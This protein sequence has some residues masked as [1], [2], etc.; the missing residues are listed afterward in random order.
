MKL[1]FEDILIDLIKREGGFVDD[2]DDRGGATNLGITIGTLRRHNLDLDGDGDVDAEDVKLVDFGVAKKLYKEHYWTPS[3]AAE[4]SPEISPLYFDM[5][6]NHGQRHA[7]RILQ[8]AANDC[9][10]SLK[11]DGVIGPNTIKASFHVDVNRVVSY[12]ILFYSAI[13]HS[14]SSQQ[15]FWFGWLKRALE[16][17]E[18]Q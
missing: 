17:W 11:V 3:K 7:A 10:Q 13:V 9:G 4:I 15:K 18:E 1:I 8:K 5:V 2:N 12:R 6:V 14:D 16:F